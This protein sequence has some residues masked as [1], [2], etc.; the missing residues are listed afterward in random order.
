MKKLRK[1]IIIIITLTLLYILYCT[2]IID[3][4]R[5][6]DKLQSFIRELGWLGIILYLFL[7][8][9]VAIFSFPSI[10]LVISAGIIY[11][12]ILGGL[13]AS[14]GALL[15]AIVNFLVSRY[16][17][18]DYVKHKIYNN[19]SFKKIDD[20]VKNNGN[21]YLLVTR[22]LPIFPYSIQSYAYGITTI[23]F[24]TYAL[25]TYILITPKIFIYTT[26]AG[27]IA[28][29]GISIKTLLYIFIA[30]VSLVLLVQIPII[31]KYINKKRNL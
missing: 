22:L 6:G 4:L 25:Y 30:S 17:A 1:I 14:I 9:L 26:L 16:I 8:I 11:G 13:L 19:P 21:Q 29:N 12:P 7:Y 27:D 23:S 18:R 20:G 3:I 28:I 31:I 2:D 15:G 10:I 24:K 5:D